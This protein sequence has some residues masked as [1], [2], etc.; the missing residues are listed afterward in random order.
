MKNRFKDVFDSYKKDI[1]KGKPIEIEGR[2]IYPIIQV[3]AFEIEDVFIYEDFTPIAIAVIEGDNR[4]L[5][6]LDEEIEE[7][8]DI[9]NQDNIWDE[10]EIK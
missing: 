4:Y 6:S 9:L 10:L 8:T 3:M 7:I 5:K 1:K 2:T